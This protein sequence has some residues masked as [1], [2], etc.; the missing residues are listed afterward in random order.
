VTE[1]SIVPGST[2][3]ATPQAERTTVDAAR[4]IK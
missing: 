4:I 3:S 1:R 2:M